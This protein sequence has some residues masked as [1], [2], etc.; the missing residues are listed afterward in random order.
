VSCIPDG[1]DSKGEAGV[2]PALSRNC[3]PTFLASQVA[4]LECV[5]ESPRIKEKVYMVGIC[6]SHC[7][8]VLALR[9]FPWQGADSYPTA[10]PAKSTIQSGDCPLNPT[11]HS[12]LD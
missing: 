2:S 6:E 3:E 9:A 10:T 12:A 1:Q 8:Q 7:C 5:Y 11:C 4:R